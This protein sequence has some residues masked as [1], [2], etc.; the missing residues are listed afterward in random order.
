[1]GPHNLLYSSGFGSPKSIQVQRIGLRI[2][3]GLFRS[4][5]AGPS[6]LVKAMPHSPRHF[7]APRMRTMAAQERRQCGH[8]AAPRGTAHT[9][10]G[11]IRR[12]TG[13]DRHDDRH[14]PGG[15]RLVDSGATPLLKVDFS[16]LDPWQEPWHQ[17]GTR[18]PPSIETSEFLFAC[19]QPEARAIGPA[20]L[21][22]S[23]P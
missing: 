13:T 1:M 14:A 18:G 2:D 21:F 12:L 23:A 9:L 7:W 15:A 11:M 8:G 17:S 6:T 16:T 19:A 5:L 22:A 3:T 10:T 4:H 20:D